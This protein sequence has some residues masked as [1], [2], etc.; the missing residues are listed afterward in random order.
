M[1][2]QTLIGREEEKK[3]KQKAAEGGSKM[4]PHVQCVNAAQLRCTDTWSKSK[5]GG[6]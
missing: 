1:S 6:H 3:K 2:E 5:R 4:F